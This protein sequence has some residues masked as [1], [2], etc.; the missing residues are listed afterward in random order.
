MAP[1]QI[2]A[3]R[4][5][6]PLERCH[7]YGRKKAHIIALSSLASFLLL[8]R[9]KRRHCSFFDVMMCKKKNTHMNAVE[10]QSRFLE[11]D[12]IVNLLDH[13]ILPRLTFTDITFFT[14]LPT[15][16]MNTNLTLTK[17]FRMTK[18]VAQIWKF[19]DIPWKAESCKRFAFAFCGRLFFCS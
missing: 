17:A 9:N 15:I 5:K 13:S 1:I 8:E 2:T 14:L 16:S 10:R 19:I 18:V 6:N 12:S 3:R 4:P 11:G 7:L